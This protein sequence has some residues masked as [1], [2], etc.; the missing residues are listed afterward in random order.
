MNVLAKVAHVVSEA[1]ASEFPEATAP[2]VQ[3]TTDPTHGDYQS[4][5]AMPLAK[6][7]KRNP[8]EVAEQLIGALKLQGLAE[9]ATIA[10]PGFINIRLSN[11]FLGKFVADVAKDPRGGV[12]P[13]TDPQTP[14]AAP[15]ER[16][17]KTRV[18]IAIVCGVIIAP[19]TPCTA[20][21]AI[22]QPIEGARP[23]AADASVKTTSPQTNTGL[24]PNLSPSRPVTSSS[25]A[26]VSR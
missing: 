22:S 13:A 24:G 19:P 2:H 18:I 17:G 12:S 14:R 5:A 21:A 6:S 20:R 1:L 16:G 10:G 15:R 26:K 8:R 4:N 23:Q 7:L 11:D 9:D 25:T 3:R